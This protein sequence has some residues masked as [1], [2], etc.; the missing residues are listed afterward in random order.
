[1]IA[2][3]N[4]SRWLFP[5]NRR[6]TW[7]LR[8]AGTTVVALSVIGGLAS[9]HAQPADF[10][11]RFEFGCESPDIMDTQSGSFTRLWHDDVPSAKIQPRPAFV[12]PSATIPLQLSNDQMARIAEAV[13]QARFWEYPTDF[14]RSGRGV[15]AEATSITTMVP[16]Q[17]YRLE[18]RRAGRV[19]SVSW[20]DKSS[21]SSEEAN[22]LRNLFALIRTIVY[23]Y[24]AVR[25]LR[26]KSPCE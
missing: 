22:R 20:D 16:Y 23:E 1:V 18:V 12:Q 6:S 5:S 13:E 10:S 8:I 19:Q 26:S 2:L 15:P 14:T 3:I 25:Q 24:P 17:S 11:F 9:V 7:R 21:P 4:L